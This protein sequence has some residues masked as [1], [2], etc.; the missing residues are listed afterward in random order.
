MLG[1]EEASLPMSRVLLVRDDA[2]AYKR[3]RGYDGCSRYFGPCYIVGKGATQRSTL[4]SRHHRGVCVICQVCNVFGPVRRKLLRWVSRR[5]FCSSDSSALRSARHVSCQC[6]TV[7]TRQVS[8]RHD[9]AGSS[10]WLV[11]RALMRLRRG[12]RRNYPELRGRSRC[13]Y[14]A[15]PLGCQQIQEFG[16]KE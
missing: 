12:R 6:A 13:K 8:Y 5:I 3:T 9:M 14:E 16:A 11:G 4:F 10:Q 15:A 1:C 2:D 7:C